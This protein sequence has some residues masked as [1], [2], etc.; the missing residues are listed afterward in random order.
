MFRIFPLH[1]LL[2]FSL[3]VALLAGMCS[4]GG[5]SLSSSLD[6]ATPAVNG[7]ARGASSWVGDECATNLPAGW[8][9][10]ECVAPPLEVTPP[11]AP[12]KPKTLLGTVG[13]VIHGLFGR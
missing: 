7:D 12:E 10:D 3:A 11:P 5:G 6:Q 4:C 2:K 13:S 8:A 9:G 1:N